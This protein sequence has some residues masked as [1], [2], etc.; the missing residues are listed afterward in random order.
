MDTHQPTWFKQWVKTDF[1]P[2]KHRIDNIVKLN[3]LKE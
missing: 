3:N 2:L 1:N